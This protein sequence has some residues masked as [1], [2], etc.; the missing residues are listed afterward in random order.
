[1]EMSASYHVSFLVFFVVIIHG[2]HSYIE[3]SLLQ[4]IPK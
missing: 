4:K 1:M 3:L 2:V